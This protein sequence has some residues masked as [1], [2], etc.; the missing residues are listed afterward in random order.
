MTILNLINK[1]AFKEKYL[2]M[3]AARSKN[4]FFNLSL[5]KS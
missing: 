3:N 4:L 1:E 5:R 2:E